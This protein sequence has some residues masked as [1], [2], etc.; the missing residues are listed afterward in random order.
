[1]NY[2][3]QITKM[4]G[5]ELDENFIVTD[6]DGERIDE[7]TYK[8]TEDGIFGKQPTSDI[9]SCQPT[10]VLR[11]ILNG[12]YAVSMRRKPKKCEKYYIYNPCSGVVSFTDWLD[13][14]IDFCRWKVG[15][16]FRTKEEAETKGKEIMEAIQREYDEA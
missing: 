6:V 3:K 10:S 14:D 2:W 15:N 13:D 9:W 11:D 1:M 7:Y 12:D 8:F 4:L 5:L 16:C